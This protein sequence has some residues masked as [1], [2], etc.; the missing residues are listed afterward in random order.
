MPSARG[1]TSQV[2]DCDSSQRAPYPSHTPHRSHALPSAH[3]FSACCVRHRAG[4]RAH[5]ALAHPLWEGR[6]RRDTAALPPAPSHARN[7]WDAAGGLGGR[8]RSRAECFVVVAA[9]VRLASCFR[10]GRACCVSWRL[11]RAH[12]RRPDATNTTDVICTGCDPPSSDPQSRSH[13]MHSPRLNR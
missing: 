4:V 1:E 2:A 9:Q 11:L 3:A 13:R 12:D 10:V 5:E 7:S 8:V 6:G